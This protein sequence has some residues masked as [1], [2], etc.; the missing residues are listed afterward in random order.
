MTKIVFSWRSALCLIVFAAVVCLSVT[1][2]LVHFEIIPEDRANLVSVIIGAGIGLLWP[3][4][5]LRLVE[6]N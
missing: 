2:A 1:M 3:S 5:V 6:G 4:R